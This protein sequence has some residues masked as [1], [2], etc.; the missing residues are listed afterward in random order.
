MQFIRSHSYS[1]VPKSQLRIP[2][3]PGDDK[4]LEC[5]DAACADYLVTGTSGIFRC[6]RNDQGDYSSGVHHVG[7][8][9]LVAVTPESS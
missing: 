9:S 2:P 4:F 5:A 1:V 8:A 3:D 7:W 6:T